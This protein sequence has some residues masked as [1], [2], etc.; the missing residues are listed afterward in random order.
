MSIKSKVLAAAAT[1]TMVGGLGAAGTLA[2][3]TASAA[4]PSCGHHCVNVFSK[5]FS[6][7]LTVKPSVVLDV[8]R[9]SARVGQPIIMFQSSNTDPGEDF[10]VT[11]QGTVAHFYAAGLVSAALKLHYAKDYAW[12]LQ[13]SPY[14]VNSGLC[15][16][17]ASTA[18]Y[19]A[20]VSLQPCGVS[21]KT[22]W[23]TDV[24]KLNKAGLFTFPFLPL[25][26]GSDT[27]FSQPFVMTYPANGN[28]VDIPRPQLVVQNLHKFSRGQ[29]YDN[30][31]WSGFFGI[32]R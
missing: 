29:V 26:N 21:A 4:T 31:M 7:V 28:P 5:K 20:T 1:L 2:A 27:N 13:Y 30:Q 8:Y 16:G 14:G 17:L 32:L 6:N 12:E 24:K 23:V 9:Q 18:I 3:G 11:R 15:V 22:I 25:I 10:T 19:N